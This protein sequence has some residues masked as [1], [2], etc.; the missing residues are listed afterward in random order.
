MSHNNYQNHQYK[1]DNPGN[2]EKAGILLLTRT[3]DPVNF[4]DL[5]IFPVS[6]GIIQ[7][8]TSRRS[9]KNP[10]I[11]ALEHLTKTVGTIEWDRSISV[12]DRCEVSSVS[13][14]SDKWTH[15]FQLLLTDKEFNKLVALSASDDDPIRDYLVSV[16]SHDVFE[17]VMGLNVWDKRDITVVAKEYEA[18][19]PHLTFKRLSS[20]DKEVK[21]PLGETNLVL[22]RDIFRKALTAVHH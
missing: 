21:L 16:S 15:C 3:A 5:Y 20:P 13:Y 9:D 22:L 18:S 4:E 12:I 11:T 10:M 14:R 2:Y 6:N 19:T 7:D 8:I 17:Y 1:C